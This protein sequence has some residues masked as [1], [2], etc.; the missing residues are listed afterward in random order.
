MAGSGSRGKLYVQIAQTI[1]AMVQ[2]GHWL[3]G[4]RLPTL[5]ELAKTFSC[6]RATVREA[7]SALR[8]QGLVEF[9][10]G[11][12]TYVK[13]A[14]VEMWMEPLEAAILLGTGQVRD[15]V[16][17]L[18]AILSGIA[19]FAA[20]HVEEV[21]LGPVRTALF[22]LECALPMEEDSVVAEVGFY[23]VLAECYGNRVLDNALRVLQEALRSALRSGREREVMGLHTCRAVFDAVAAGDASAARKS[24]YDYG[25]ELQHQ[26]TSKPGNTA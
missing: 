4:D 26:L 12:G 19:S 20:D 13:T 24:V 21:D 5:V 14:T 7:L 16:E 8:G 22:Q 18:T 11:D 9:R 25:L 6:S 15:L 1:R 17:V 23:L 3:P 2:E 10:H